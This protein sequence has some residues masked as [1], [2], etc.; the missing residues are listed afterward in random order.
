M[1]LPT[2]QGQPVSWRSYS[3]ES[4]EPA[5]SCAPQVIDRVDVGVGQ[6][7][8][9]VLRPGGCRVGQ[10]TSS[11]QSSRSAWALQHY[12]GYFTL[13]S[14]EQGIKAGSPTF[15]PS[16]Q[17]HSHLHHQGQPYWVAQVRWNGQSPQFWGGQ[18]SSPVLMTL[19]RASS[20]TWQRRKMRG[21]TRSPAPK[22]SG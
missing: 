6:H 17:A 1:G 5:P 2:R 14:K 11:P 16:G 13:D 8:A 4:A 22:F 9:P 10:P 7:T 18:N 15:I 21:G 3:S 12:P 19:G 20:P